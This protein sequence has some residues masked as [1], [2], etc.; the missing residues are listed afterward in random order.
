MTDLNV[1][2]V[3]GRLV[4][5]AE[6]KFSSTGMAV[7][8]FSIAVNRGKKV[9]EEW[10]DEVSFFDV[11]LFGKSGEN[12][13][14]YLLKGTQV[15]LQGELRQNRWEQDGVKR[16]KVALIANRV[17]LLGSRSAATSQQ[18]MEHSIMENEGVNVGEKPKGSP[19]FD[20]DIP[21]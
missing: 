10:V 18:P 1:V 14:R 4:R 3:V 19:E 12:L 16:S 5:N 2:F 7:C 15:A 13:Q 20:D 11:T 21:F 9:N 17:Q 8:E 6:L